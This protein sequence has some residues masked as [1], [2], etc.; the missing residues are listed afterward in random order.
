VAVAA[1]TALDELPRWQTQ[2]FGDAGHLV[3]AALPGE[4]RIRGA[5]LGQ[6]GGHA[7]EVDL[8]AC[9]EGERSRRLETHEDLATGMRF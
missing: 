7:P 8:H 4:D 5:Q 6:D 3:N 9:P 1:R 2:H